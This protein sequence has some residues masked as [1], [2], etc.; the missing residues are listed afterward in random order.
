MS[1]LEILLVIVLVP[2]VVAALAFWV[3]MLVDCLKFRRP[4][5]WKD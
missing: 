4:P 2:V 1:P 5:I 3:W